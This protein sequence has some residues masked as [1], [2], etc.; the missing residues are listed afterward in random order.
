MAEQTITCPKCGTVIPLSD[1][2]TDKIRHQLEDEMGKEL[3][4]KEKTLGEREKSLK[5]SQKNIDEQV[6]KRVEAEKG[7]MREEAE[8]KAAEKL[9]VEF[10]D[11][12]KANEEKEGQIKQMREQ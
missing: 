8:T 12:Q 1:A 5:E 11:L 7:K 9:G 6:A 4:E 3:R 2:L 10:K